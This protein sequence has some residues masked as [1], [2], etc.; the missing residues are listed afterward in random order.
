MVLYTTFFLI[1]SISYVNSGILHPQFTPTRQLL[2]LNGLWYFNLS[3]NGSRWYPN[4]ETLH[5][6]PVP[7]SYNDIGTEET[8]RHHVGI[9]E[10]QRKFIVP[11][12][13]SSERVWLR[14]SSVCTSAE[15]VS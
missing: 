3:E 5:L 14:F 11:R 7:S 15:V 2:P 6:M 12:T 1:V 4:H 9:A 8:L 13:W 10:Y